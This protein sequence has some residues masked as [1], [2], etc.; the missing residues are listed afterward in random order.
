M[1]NCALPPLPRLK[2]GQT[3]K[4]DYRIKPRSDALIIR[5]VTEMDAG[6]YTIILSNKNTKEEQR[7]SFQLLVNGMFSLIYHAVIPHHK[8]TLFHCHG[9]NFD[10]LCNNRD[11]EAEPKESC[12]CFWIFVPIML[13]SNTYYVFLITYNVFRIIL[14][15]YLSCIYFILWCLKPLMYV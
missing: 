14:A 13:P 1:L 4:Y 2:N 12:P 9:Y 15:L 10:F 8:H 6:N 3:L 11:L 5:G 7:R